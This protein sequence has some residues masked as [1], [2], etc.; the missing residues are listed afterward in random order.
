MAYFIL[1]V[2]LLFP[3]FTFAMPKLYFRHGAVAS[4]KTLNLLAVAHNYR[5]QGKNVMVIKPGIDTR[6]GV[7]VVASRAGLQQKADVIVYPDTNLLNITPMIENLHCVLVDEVQFLQPQ[8]VEQLRV[9]T[10]K[11]DVP[12]VLFQHSRYIPRMNHCVYRFAM[13]Y[14]L[15]SALNCSLGASDYLSL[16][17][18][19]KR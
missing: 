9:I 10:L 3:P 6:F 14:V 7:D 2:A 18:I 13:V 4:A 15:I 16:Q 17:I 19:L 12:V 8:Q 1:A 11:W 5:Q